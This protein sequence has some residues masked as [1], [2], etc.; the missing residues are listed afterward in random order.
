MKKLFLLLLT[1]ASTNVLF[2]VRP[3]NERTLSQTK[4]PANSMMSHFQLPAP[5]QTANQA[6]KTTTKAPKR[7][8]FAHIQKRADMDTQTLP[9][10]NVGAQTKPSTNRA[11]DK[12]QLLM[13]RVTTSAAAVILSQLKNMHN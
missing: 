10:Q 13:D 2:G 5:Q 11:V 9:L 6:Q 8:L 12:Q 7:D 1:L 4:N 3:D